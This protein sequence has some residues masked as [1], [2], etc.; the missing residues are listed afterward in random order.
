MADGVRS[1]GGF[2]CA[3]RER[4]RQFDGVSLT[5]EIVVTMLLPTVVRWQS[6][7]DEVAVE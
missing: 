5:G 1:G 3:R 7:T 6:Q 2:V 4:F